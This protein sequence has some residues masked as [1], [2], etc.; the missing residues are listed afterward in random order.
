MAYTTLERC[1]AILKITSTADNDL[2][3]DAIAE[4]QDAIDQWCGRTFEASADTT[5]YFDS[6]AIKGA[7]LTI[8]ELAQVTSVIVAGQTLDPTSYRL[9][10]RNEIPYTSIRL[11]NGGSWNVGLDDEVAIAGRWAYSVESP[12]TITRAATRLACY[13]Y[14]MAIEA[15]LMDVVANPEMGTVTIAK[16]IPNDVRMLLQNLRRII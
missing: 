6:S 14:K 16:G 1:R 12:K 10:P 11:L 4:A 2:I 8:D 7:T 13:Y 3:E 5:R 9:E 15:P